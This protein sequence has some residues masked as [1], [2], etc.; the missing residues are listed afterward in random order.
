MCLFWP[1]NHFVGGLKAIRSTHTLCFN[2]DC[3]AM[4][5]EEASG[6]PWSR[7]ATTNA[8]DGKPL[9][10]TDKKSKEPGSLEAKSPNHHRVKD[11]QMHTPYSTSKAQSQS[12]YTLHTLDFGV[13]A[14]D[15]VARQRK[16]RLRCPTGRDQ[17]KESSVET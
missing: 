17:P 8:V 12:P 3:F 16:V 9:N 7:D 4:V 11:F 2:L 6:F 13:V 1:L 5:L 14:R 10:P 15:K